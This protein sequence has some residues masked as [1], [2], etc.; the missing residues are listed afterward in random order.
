MKVTVS[1]GSDNKSRSLRSRERLAQLGVSFGC[2][3]LKWYILRTKG[4]V[5]QI[6]L[7][8]ASPHHHALSLV[9]GP[10]RSTKDTG[11]P[12]KA[13]ITRHPEGVE[14]YNSRG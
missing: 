6:L 12:N 13:E 5:D 7:E 1:L 3:D 10:A 2:G 14:K 8:V 4:W 9:T 11:Y